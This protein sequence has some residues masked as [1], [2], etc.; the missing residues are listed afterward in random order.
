M[1]S[2][3]NNLDYFESMLKVSTFCR[4]L[5]KIKESYKWKRSV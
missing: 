4:E 5:A 2:L 1:G 3:A